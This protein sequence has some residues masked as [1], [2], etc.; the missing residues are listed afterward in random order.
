M[1]HWLSVCYEH[2]Q[3]NPMSYPTNIHVVDVHVIEV[4]SIY[5]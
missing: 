3:L 5:S 1:K 4:C 2:E